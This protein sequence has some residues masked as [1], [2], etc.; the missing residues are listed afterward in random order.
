MA[1]LSKDEILSAKL[2]TRE[3]DVPEWGGA[4]LVRSMTAFERDK[5]EMYLQR[6]KETAG[7]ASFSTRAYVAS[8]TIVGEDGQRLFSDEDVQIL[9]Q[10]SAHAL[11]R[12][13][14]AVL[15]LSGME[16]GAIEDAEKNSVG[17]LNGSGGSGSPPVSDA[18]LANCNSA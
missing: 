11:D 1:L 14:D 5:F 4:V 2:P 12:I 13:L 15:S 10:K 9:G 3:V 6:Q 17:G 7:S 16:S 18:Q 8:C